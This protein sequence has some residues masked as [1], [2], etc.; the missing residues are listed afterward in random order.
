MGIIGWLGGENHGE[1]GLR[2]EPF[3][4]IATLYKHEVVVVQ[5]LRKKVC[6]LE[7]VLLYAFFELN[8]VLGNARAC[9]L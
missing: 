1:G 9:E 8:I 3:R 4:K 2:S 5:Q 6:S 7:V